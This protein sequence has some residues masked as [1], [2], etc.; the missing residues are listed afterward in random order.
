MPVLS[1]G[2][3]VLD[4]PDQIAAYRLLVLKSR[5]SLSLKIP[6]MRF[7]GPSVFSIVK[8]EF[9]LKGSKQKVYDQFCQILREKG[10]LQ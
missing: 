3:I 1:N 5:M 9:D 6:Q 2:T 4:T 7:R 8:K 10:I